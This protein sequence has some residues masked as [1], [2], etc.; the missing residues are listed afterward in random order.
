MYRCGKRFRRD[1]DNARHRGESCSGIV[2]DSRS[3]VKRR[4]ADAG[5]RALASITLTKATIASPGD[6]ATFNYDRAADS[7]IS[8]TPQAN[9]ASGSAQPFAPQGPPAI[10]SLALWLDADAPA[11]VSQSAGIVTQWAD[12]SSNAIPFTQGT[13]GNQPAYVT[14][15]LNGLPVIR[16]ASVHAADGLTTSSERDRLR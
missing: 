1:A 2:Y 10:P 15:A 8:F 12:R 11:T 14:G 13:P 16:F 3:D 7:G 5:A 6:A 4:S 9:G